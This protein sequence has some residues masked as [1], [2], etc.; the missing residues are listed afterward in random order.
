[1]KRAN[2]I[3]VYHKELAMSRERE[4]GMAPSPPGLLPA[5]ITLITGRRIPTLTIVYS[6]LARMTSAIISPRV[7]LLLRSLV[8]CLA[9]V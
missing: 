1:M 8:A 3:G 6:S 7:I 9:A 4:Q 2:R 5:L